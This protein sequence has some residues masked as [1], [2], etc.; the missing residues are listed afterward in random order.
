MP[1][2]EPA[3]SAVNL[4]PSVTGPGSFASSMLGTLVS[5]N[6]VHG[7]TPGALGGLAVVNDPD[8]PVVSGLPCESVALRVTVCLTKPAS[9]DEGVK[10]TVRVVALYDVVPGTVTLLASLTATP[11]LL[12]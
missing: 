8:L 6:R 1:V 4:T 2:T 3:R 7:H 12:S 9:G 10:V 11:T 5:S